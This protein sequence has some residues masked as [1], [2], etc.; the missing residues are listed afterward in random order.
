MTN[1]DIWLRYHRYS[2]D[3]VQCS[4]FT[5]GIISNN[6]QINSVILFLFCLT[7]MKLKILLI[8]F[9]FFIQTPSQRI[10]HISPS[11]YLSSSPLLLLQMHYL[12]FKVMNAG[13]LGN[14]LTFRI[15]GTERLKIAHRTF[16]AKITPTLPSKLFKPI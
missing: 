10:L 5:T 7:S 15:S 8:F 13:K 2:I 4:F 9:F 3:Y 14:D 1:I 6:N 16:V 12:P 11:H